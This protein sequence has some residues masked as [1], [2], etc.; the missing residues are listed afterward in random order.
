MGANAIPG[1]GQYW[2]NISTGAI[3]KG[4]QSDWSRLLGPYATAQEA[5]EALAKVE[6]RN[7]AWDAEDE[8]EV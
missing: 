3:E 7:E 6:A 8:E 5:Q 1:E 2:Y 4:P